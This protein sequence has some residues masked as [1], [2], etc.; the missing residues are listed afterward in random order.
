[1]KTII[2]I[3]LL[4]GIN[5]FAQLEIEIQRKFTNLN[6][7][8]TIDVGAN[9]NQIKVETF[10]DLNY[11]VTNDG[12]FNFSMII[13]ANKYFTGVSDTYYDKFMW[14]GSSVVSEN[15]KISAFSYGFYENLIN[16]DLENPSLVRSQ[17]N[18][19][20]N[21]PLVMKYLYKKHGTNYQIR[22]TQGTYRDRSREEKNSVDPMLYWEKNDGKV[23]A[24]YYTRLSKIS[25]RHLPQY[26][27]RGLKN[28]D[29]L[30]IYIKN[31]I[32]NSLPADAPSLAT[33]TAE[34]KALEQQYGLLD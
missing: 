27:Y 9:T 17:T 4:A 22:R 3:F 7:F 13:V 12:V 34:H 23:Y 24:F 5:L 32:G 26:Y 31:R 16:M 29:S 33:L 15:E 11:G 20:K 8:P 2:L 30:D 21:L 14:N 18:Y 25:I 28:K 1:M 10:A 19:E 6:P